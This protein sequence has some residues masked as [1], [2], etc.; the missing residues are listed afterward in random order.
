MTP[1][2]VKDLLSVLNKN[3]RRQVVDTLI[4]IVNPTK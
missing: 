2:K 3:T 1:K 4:P